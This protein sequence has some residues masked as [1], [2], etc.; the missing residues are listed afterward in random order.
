MDFDLYTKIVDDMSGNN[1]FAM[2]MNVLGEPLI[3]KRIND[4]VKYAKQKGIIDVFFH[5]NAVLLNEKASRALIESGLDRLVIS[6]DSPYKEKYEA[7]RINAKYDQVLKNVIRFNQIRSE[8]GSVGPLTRLNFI[9]LPGVTEQE[10][11]DV[12]ELFKPH[13]DSIGLLDYVEGDNDVRQTIEVEEGY[14]SK[15]VCSQVLTRLTVYDD[16]SVLPCCSDY[17]DELILGN[18]ATQSIQEIW[19]CD[20]LN[21]IRQL[22]FSGQF[23]KIPA[24]AKCDYAQQADRKYRTASG[25]K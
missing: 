6:F 10:I 25:E 8:M 24:C 18:L 19:N 1:V 22:H 23:Y 4:M 15:F 12:I 13:I 3:H 9:K 17:D 2:N 21:E 16:G 5:T 7:V 11:T 14:K 20:K